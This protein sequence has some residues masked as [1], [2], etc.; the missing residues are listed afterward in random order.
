MKRN[1]KNHSLREWAFKVSIVMK[2]HST[3]STKGYL[4]ATITHR[5][6]R[7]RFG[8]EGSGQFP[9]ASW[10]SVNS[11]VVGA[12]KQADVV[13]TSIE[14][15][16]SLLQQANSSVLNSYERASI[17]GPDQL[18]SFI[19]SYDPLAA[20]QGIRDA[21]KQQTQ[22]VNKE[23]SLTALVDRF[24][25]EY[26]LTRESQGVRLEP[27][28][29]KNYKSMRNHV[30]QFE[31]HWG[32]IKLVDL[33]RDT[34]SAHLFASRWHDWLESSNGHSQPTVGRLNKELNTVFRWV[35]RYLASNGQKFITLNASA[36]T[37]QKDSDAVLT[38]DEIDAIWNLE[39]T[40]QSKLDTVRLV[41]VLAAE[42]GTRYSDISSISTD[43]CV[44][45]LNCQLIE[46]GKT[47]KEQTI[48]HSERVR[49]ILKHFNSGWPKFVSNHNYNSKFNIDI[50]AVCKL[51]GLD[52]M[53]R[54]KGRMRPLCD[55]ISSHCFRKS[56][57]TNKFLVGLGDEVIRKNIWS[58]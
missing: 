31:N 42:V 10:N 19:E 16:A 58:R 27:G 4:N 17:C 29:L 14:T 55:V 2:K 39:L 9:V 13:R 56:S 23:E 21:Y 32:K 24:I 25:A 28:T 46:Q 54:H 47:G 3:T 53:V 40:G 48:V 1:S 22:I 33:H 7:I 38:Y 52:R 57:I 36:A 34:K 26:P 37:R 11:S 51:A 15:L 20:L 30:E 41:M 49:S 45:A 6:K 44:V 12:S 18:S 50:R 8:I 43:P 35:E 5:G